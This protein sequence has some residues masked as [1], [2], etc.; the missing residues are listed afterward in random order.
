MAVFLVILWV[1]YAYVWVKGDLNW[2]KPEPKIPTLARPI[3]QPV[4]PEPARI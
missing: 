2:D 1:G 4:R 3:H